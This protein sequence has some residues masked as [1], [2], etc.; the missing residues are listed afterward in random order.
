MKSGKALGLWILGV[1]LV[2]CLS[3]GVFAL[4]GRA[5]EAE[6]QKLTAKFHNEAA[7]GGYRIVTT[8]EFKA[9]LDQLDP[10]WASDMR[11]LLI[12]DTTPLDDG[13]RKHHIPGAVPFEFPSDEVNRLDDKT[14]AEFEE[15]LGPD[16]NRKVVFYGRDTRCGRSHNG[17]M[18]AAKLGYTR[19]YRY[20]DGIKGWLE[21]G[22]MVDKTD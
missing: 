9:W 14:K 2:L 13:F 20:P 22:Y 15:L 8:G 19:V 3:S 4:G 16:K 10:R 11:T 1:A 5:D 17:A 6:A 12:V 18:W 7:G 21:A